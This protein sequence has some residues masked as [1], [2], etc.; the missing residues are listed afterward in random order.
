MKR[1]VILLL[2]L[3][4]AS[5]LRLW[6]I[7]DFAVFLGDEG[8]DALIVKRIIVDHRPTL[9]GPMTSV[10]NMYLGP[11][12]YYLMIIPLWLTRLDPI[13]PAIMVAM[14]GIFTVFLIYLTGVEFFNKTAGLIA[15]LFYTVSPLVIIHTHSSWNPNPMP[16]FALLAIYS[17]LK[18]IKTKKRK[19]LVALGLSLGITTQLHYFS[20][21]LI[22]SIFLI[23]LVF[24]P[25]LS[26][27]DYLL[28][29]FSFTLILIPQILF[30][31]RHNFLITK[32]IINFLKDKEIAGM[33]IID[34]LISFFSL[35]RRLF[36]NLIGVNHRF[37]GGI[38]AF[39]SGVFGL[40]VLV[41]EKD[42]LKKNLGLT[43]TVL[44]IIFG[45]FGVGLYP[46]E[47][48]DHYF[49]FLF[50]APFLLFSFFVSRICNSKISTPVVLIIV[51]FLLFLNLK[52]TPLFAEGKPGF[53]I[54]RAKGIAKIIA[55]DV[56]KERFNLVWVSPVRDFR[57]MNYRYF[58]EVFGKPAE[59]YINYTDI[60]TLY[61]IL[62]GDNLELKGLSFWEIESF[63]PAIIEKKWELDPTT[64]I[65]KLK[66]EET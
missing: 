39:L 57:G 17:L 1:W 60:E 61:V 47:I 58:L 28:L 53:Q 38:L 52:K 43:I 44:W 14:I 64:K 48:H 56:N 36:I 37:L 41:K 46:G 63:G 24:R 50:P 13:G 55:Q 19:W 59:D 45:V 4:L 16:F 12:Y 32:S 3:S 5:F 18:V 35:Y 21:V 9:L 8:R 65:Y 31:L 26:F 20:F 51:S 30:E 6:R 7:D 54:E 22:G 29:F 42:F 15:G 27:S 2:I 62:E 25:K 34:S 40:F 49:G 33:S 23:F 66:K 11:V 10:G